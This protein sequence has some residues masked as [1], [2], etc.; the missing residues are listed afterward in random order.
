[1]QS[2]KQLT[3]SLALYHPNKTCDE[4]C[5]FYDACMQINMC[6]YDCKDNADENY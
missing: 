1:L 4:Y 3:Q 2:L 5:D 6:K